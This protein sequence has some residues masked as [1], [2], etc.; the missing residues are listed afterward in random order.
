MFKG[1]EPLMKAIRVEQ[2][3][4]PEVMQYADIP[5]K[6]VVSHH[7]I[8]E[9]KAVG[10]NPVDTYIRSGNYSYAA[11]MPF[12]PGFDG[13]GIIKK[14]SK[15]VLNLHV[16]EKV[17]VTGKSSGTYAQ[18]VMIDASQVY[19]LPD[20]LNFDQGAAIGIPYATAYRALFHKAKAVADEIVFIHGA[21]GGVG[22]AALQLAKMAQLKVIAS[23]GS[24]AGMTLVQQLGADYVIDHRKKDVVEEVM[25]ATSGNGVD[26]ILE[27][28]ANVN[29]VDDLKVVAKGGRIIVI[30]NRGSVKI[31]PRDLMLRDSLVSGMLIFNTPVD[32]M[33][34]IHK[35]LYEAFKTECVFPIIWQKFILEDAASAHKKIEHSRALGKVVLIP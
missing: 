10:V 19:P 33:K 15:E 20:N 22:L 17:Y 30:G 5:E 9:M 11:D 23:A 29:L 4:S 1:I 25:K 2:F 7:V 32:D 28:L 14:T 26:I 8:V 18:E 21:S 12:T 31:N 6:D 3:G 13:A 16:G 34:R 24:K 27:M 35:S